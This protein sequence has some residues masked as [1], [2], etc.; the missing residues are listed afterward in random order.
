MFLKIF[1]DASELCQSNDPITFEK[2]S[3]LLLLIFCASDNYFTDLHL[4][5]SLSTL[6]Q[7]S[8][9]WL[10]IKVKDEDWKP[11][12]RNNAFFS[13]WSLVH[14]SPSSSSPWHFQTHTRLT[15]WSTFCKN[16]YPKYKILMWV[17]HWFLL[18]LKTN[19]IQIQIQINKIQSSYSLSD[20]WQTLEAS[21]VIK[22]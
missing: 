16:I 10:M 8:K 21:M 13:L 20:S 9:T 5:P 22:G 18:K 2:K 7:V 11:N 3:L 19:Q 1:K 14:S 4:L 12:L 17:V 6:Y 15:G